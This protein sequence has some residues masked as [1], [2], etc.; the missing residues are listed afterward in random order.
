MV[1]YGE[2][3]VREAL[4]FAARRFDDESAD[5]LLVAAY[6][7]AEGAAVPDDLSVTHGAV[8]LYLQ[9]TPDRPVLASLDLPRLRALAVPDSARGMAAA[10]IHLLA[11]ALP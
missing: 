2:Q 4:E 5:D 10:L 11:A 9:A 8:A 6:E 3:D 1:L 7:S